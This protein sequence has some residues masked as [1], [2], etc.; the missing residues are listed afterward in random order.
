M[1]LWL[2]KQSKSVKSDIDVLGATS[3]TANG[4]PADKD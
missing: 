1:D 4:S 2:I 3:S